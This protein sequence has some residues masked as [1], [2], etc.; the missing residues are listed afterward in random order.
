M[1]L[2]DSLPASL[3]AV[4]YIVIAYYLEVTGPRQFA[5]REKQ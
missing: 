1:P 3:Q 5:H 2:T 4:A